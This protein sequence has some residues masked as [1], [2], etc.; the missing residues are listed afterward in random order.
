MKA[1]RSLAFADVCG[2]GYALQRNRAAVCAVDI[3][4]HAL[5]SAAHGVFVGVCGRTHSAAKLPV[6][7]R[8]DVADK[9]VYVK[10]RAG[11]VKLRAVR[12]PRKQSVHPPRAFHYAAL[13]AKPSVK[14]DIPQRGIIHQRLYIFVADIAAR[15]RYKFVR[16]KN[17]RALAARRAFKTVHDARVYQRALPRRKLRRARRKPKP[18]TAAVYHKQLKLPVTVKRRNLSCFYLLAI[19]LHGKSCRARRRY[20]VMLFNFH[21]VKNTPYNLNWEDNNINDYPTKC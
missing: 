2:G 3:I 21:K 16:K 10:L 4:R 20:C 7:R 17:I 15:G 9:A 5:Y 6:Q 1:A 19:K 13:P 18:H 8:P 14:R 12:Y 11:S